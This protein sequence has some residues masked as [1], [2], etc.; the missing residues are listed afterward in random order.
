[1]AMIDIE[2]HRFT[3]KLVG[4]PFHQ[5]TATATLSSSML[6]I[7]TTSYHNPSYQCTVTNS[8][9][10]TKKFTNSYDSKATNLNCTSLIM[11]HQKIQAC[12]PNLENNFVKIQARAPNTYCLSKFCKDL[13]QKDIMLNILYPCTT[14][15]ILSPYKALEGMFSFNRTP[16][17]P[18]GTEVTIHI[19]PVQRQLWGYHAI[20]TWYS[21]PALTHY[22]C[23]K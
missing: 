12:N 20:H 23:I 6:S 21:A 13:E 19:K 5:T 14:N 18:I 10:H 9:K 1:M 22:Q 11:R 3:D 8:S 2:G 15:P 17:A 16:M 7:Q 4:F